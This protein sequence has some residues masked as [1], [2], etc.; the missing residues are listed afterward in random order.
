MR[1]LKTWWSED[2]GNR[3]YMARCRC[4]NFMNW[5]RL[6]RVGWECANCGRV[7]RDA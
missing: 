6:F 7:K 5:R 4:G 3:P 1:S 2:P